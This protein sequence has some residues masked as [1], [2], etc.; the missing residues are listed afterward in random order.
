VRLE[1]SNC[2][3]R[4]MRW[5]GPYRELHQRFTRQ[6]NEEQAGKQAHYSG[7]RPAQLD[8]LGSYLSYI[9]DG[10]I[11]GLDSGRLQD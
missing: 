10:Q 6:N 11:A 8:S 4:A 1:T 5:A 3:T 9:R 7:T 2:S